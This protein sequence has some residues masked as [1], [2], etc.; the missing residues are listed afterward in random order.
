MKK[1]GKEVLFLDTRE[2]HPRNGEGTLIN[3]KNGDILYLFTEYIGNERADHSNSRLSACIS[4]DGGESW[5]APTPMIEKGEGVVNIMSPSLI[6]MSNGDLGMV[7]LQKDA[8]ADSGIS[9]M[10]YFISSSDEGK[11]WSEPIV[12]SHHR[13]YYC[14]INDGV[15]VQKSG[16]ILVPM[17]YCGELFYP[18]GGFKER[19]GGTVR[20][21]FSDDCGRTWHDLPA[22]IKSPY[23]DLTGLAEP[24]V[25]E[26]EDGELWMWCRT[27]YGFQ[28]Q[29]HSKDGGITWSQAAPNL[30]FSSPDAP[31]RV[32]KVGKYTVAVF[33]PI[34]HNYFSHSTEDWGAPKR[35]PLACAVSLDDGRSFQLS[36]KGSVNSDLKKMADLLY[37]I[38]DDTTESYCYPA[39]TDTGDGFTVGYYHSGGTGHALTCNK[40]SKIYYE[41]LE[42]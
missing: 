24:G 30:F 28:Y 14:V 13:A 15:I 12:C 4:R 27:S 1:I 2:G 16:R 21:A 3:L 17:A 6:R 25:Y 35:T 20:F 9:C 7:Y 34:P 29:S 42:N 40:I 5:S 19:Q 11:S 31:M 22:E 26:H 23:P 10:P 36:N 8:C 37:L 39:I 38:E 41:E 32:K 33:N 18:E